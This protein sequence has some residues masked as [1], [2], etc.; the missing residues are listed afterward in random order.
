MSSGCKIDECLKSITSDSYERHI[1]VGGFEKDQ[2]CDENEA[3]EDICQ[4]YI[5]Q[6]QTLFKSDCNSIG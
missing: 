6:G 4:Q 2:P 5:N 1:I 3:S